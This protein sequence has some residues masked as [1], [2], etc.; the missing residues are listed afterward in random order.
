MF[1]KIERSDDWTI[2]YFQS[3][4][5]LKEN[6]SLKNRE[7][8]VQFVGATQTDPVKV[9]DDPENDLVNDPVKSNIL[10]YL[11][12]NPKSN[13]GELAEKTGYSAT[14][15][16]RHIQELKKLGL[17][18]RFGSDKKGFWKIIEK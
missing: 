4:L 6:Y 17:I 11:N 15:I 18:E 3:V 7:M 8:H 13:Y 1:S 14:T 16:K 9:K 5:L 12:Q 10:Y 2:T